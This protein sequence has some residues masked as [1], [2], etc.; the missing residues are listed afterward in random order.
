VL[1]PTAGFPHIKGI[2]MKA[3]LLFAA[4]LIVGIVVPIGAS[5]H[6]YTIGSIHIGHPWARATVPGAQTGGAYLK[7]DNSG[8]ADRLIS[9]SGK[10][11]DSSELHSMSMDGNVMKMD[12]LDQGLVIP[13]GKT[14]ELKPGSTHIMLVGLK[15]PLKEGTMFPLRLKFEKAGEITVD[16]KVEGMGAGAPT[17]DHMH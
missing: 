7:L 1:Y 17:A 14:V 6:D 11:S 9:V 4:A 8:A 15:S 10:V 2:N 13:Q 16:V 3:R 12:K 5:A